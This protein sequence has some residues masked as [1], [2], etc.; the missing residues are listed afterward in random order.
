MGVRMPERTTTPTPIL[1]TPTPNAVDPKLAAALEVIHAAG[2][3]AVQQGSLI[4]ALSAEADPDAVVFVVGANVYA[5][6]QA[7]LAQQH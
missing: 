5:Q 3:Q 1:L 2:L 7:R 6:V 4:V